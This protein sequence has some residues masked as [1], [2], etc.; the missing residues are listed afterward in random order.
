MILFVT[1]ILI[2]FY[3]RDQKTD[4]GDPENLS[5]LKK[6]SGLDKR[7]FGDE[8]RIAQNILKKIS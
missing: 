2:Y 5:E 3:Y 6:D 1:Y 4:P 8:K 7:Y